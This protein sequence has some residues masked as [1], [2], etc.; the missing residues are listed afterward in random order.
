MLRGASITGSADRPRRA[1]L[2]PAPASSAS[3]IGASSARRRPIVS[4]ASI[5]RGRSR[6]SR[7]SNCVP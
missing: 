2:R 6:P 7:I 1:R 3:G 5:G 4:G